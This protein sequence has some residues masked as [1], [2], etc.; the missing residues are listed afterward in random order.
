MNA[1]AIAFDAASVDGWASRIASCWQQS[2]QGIFDTGTLIAEAKAAL[3]HGEFLVLT[4]SKL[5]FTA[6][7]AQRLM[8][9]AADERLSNATHVSRLPARLVTLFY[10]TPLLH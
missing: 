3:P 5:P 10:I 1:L 4:Q 9:I 8:A 6:R 2:V 7:T